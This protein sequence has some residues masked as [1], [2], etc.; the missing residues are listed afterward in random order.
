MDAQQPSPSALGGQSTPLAQ[1]KPTGPVSGPVLGAFIDGV[2]STVDKASLKV[3]KG[4]KKYKD[5][6]FIWNPIEDQ[7][8]ALQ[9]GLNPGTGAAGTG[10]LPGQQNQ[11]GQPGQ[12]IGTGAAGTGIPGNAPTSS[13][14]GTSGADGT[15][16]PGTQPPP[17]GPGPQPSPEPPQ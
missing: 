17:F 6:E 15:N 14:S 8:A 3:Y 9:Q 1:L 2:G 7:A 4:G 11:P 10:I 16:G 12:P 13:P 5:W